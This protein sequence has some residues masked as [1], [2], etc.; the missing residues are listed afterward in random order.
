MDDS[1]P[2]RCPYGHLLLGRGK[3]IVGWMSC[4][5]PSALK[6]RERGS[7]Y[8]HT[9]TRC[10]QCQ[11]EGRDTIHHSPPHAAATR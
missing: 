9:Y 4:D 6:A 8:G 5:C 2:S 11:S 7:G 1:R 3:I 10:L